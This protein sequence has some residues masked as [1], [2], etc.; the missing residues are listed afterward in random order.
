VPQVF[1]DFMIGVLHVVHQG[2]SRVKT[3]ASQDSRRHA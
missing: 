3:A 2:L 1:Q